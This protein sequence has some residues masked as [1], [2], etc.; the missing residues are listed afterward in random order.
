MIGG[1][2]ASSLREW[3]IKFESESGKRVAKVGDVKMIK[4]ILHCHTQSYLC[5]KHKLVIKC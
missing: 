1:A 4:K 2:F 3:S 5:V